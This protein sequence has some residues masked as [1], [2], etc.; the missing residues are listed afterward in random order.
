MSALEKFAIAILASSLLVS[1]HSINQRDSTI[2]TTKIFGKW[3]YNLTLNG[4]TVGYK[5]PPDSD[6]LFK[7]WPAQGQAGEF[8]TIDDKCLLVDW[9]IN[10]VTSNQIQIGACRGDL[11]QPGSGSDGTQIMMPD[12]PYSICKIENPPDY[13]YKYSWVTCSKEEGGPVCLGNDDSYATLR[14][15]SEDYPTMVY[16]PKYVD[17][18][19]TRTFEE[20][21]F[22]QK[23]EIQD[24]FNSSIEYEDVSERL[25]CIGVENDN[26]ETSFLAL[27]RG[28][29]CLSDES[30][31]HCKEFATKEECRR[32]YLSSGNEN[33]LHF[34]MKPVLEENPENGSM[35]I[36]VQNATSQYDGFYLATFNNNTER[37]TYCMNRTGKCDTFTVREQCE[38]HL[39]T[40][41]LDNDFLYPC[42]ENAM[43]DGNSWCYQVSEF[44]S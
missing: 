25:F 27:L 20:N 35:C 16:H 22:F 11:F 33:V 18:Y 15:C 43:R 32:S 38:A 9:N 28:A 3:N 37:I 44:L 13:Y 10:E 40:I 24:D 2:A 4:D 5:Y 19:H 29:L 6:I 26:S 41:D 31:L 12:A 39:V 8:V 36:L 23:T 7:S 21:I 14:P 17:D 30:Q 42:S 34:T 1:S